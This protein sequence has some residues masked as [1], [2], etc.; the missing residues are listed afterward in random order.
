MGNDEIPD[1]AQKGEYDLVSAAV[2]DAALGEFLGTN[3]VDIEYDLPVWP[4]IE[5]VEGSVSIHLSATISYRDGQA[6]YTLPSSPILV[7]F[8][9]GEGKAV[10]STFRVA[11]NGTD[12]MMLALQY[13][14]YNL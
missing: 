8:S 12:D 14:M 13:M 5:N 11:K 9:A 7:S 1:D 6:S 4:P 10:F 2:S 3:Y